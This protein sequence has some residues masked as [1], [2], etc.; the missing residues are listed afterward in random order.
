V[1]IQIIEPQADLSN[2]E[3]QVESELGLKSVALVWDDGESLTL[4]KKK[5]GRLAADYLLEF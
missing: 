5:V 3:S 1:K 2:L 4:L